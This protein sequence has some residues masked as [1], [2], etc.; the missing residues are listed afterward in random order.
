MK[1]DKTIAE[2]GSDFHEVMRE[3]LYQFCKS[4]GILWLMKKMNLE[5]KDWIKEKENHELGISS[6]GSKNLR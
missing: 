2:V 1:H 4:F 3:L 6:V 5:M